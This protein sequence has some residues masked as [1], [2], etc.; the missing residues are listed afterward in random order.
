MTTYRLIAAVTV[1]A[2]T[3]VQANSE[4]EAITEAEDRPVVLGDESIGN[5]PYR[6]WLI[7]DADG[8]PSGVMAFAQS[9]TAA[10][11]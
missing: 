5:D 7:T 6:V 8:E 4:E 1:S 9:L 10:G 11:P 3:Y 2:Y